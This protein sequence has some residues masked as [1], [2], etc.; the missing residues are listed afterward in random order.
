MTAAQE[1]GMWKNWAKLPF[2]LKGK[3]QRS[4]YDAN[5]SRKTELN[6]NAFSS[7]VFFETVE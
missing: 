1:T 3:R 4:T 6:S 2:F 7:F 5:S